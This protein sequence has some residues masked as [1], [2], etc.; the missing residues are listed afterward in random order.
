MYIAGLVRAKYVPYISRDRRRARGTC[1][2][3]ASL[4]HRYRARVH[5]WLS[6]REHC[7][8]ARSRWLHMQ[9]RERNM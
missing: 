1:R 4:Q 5:G 7:R 2:V 6:T 9:Q 3:A 8:E